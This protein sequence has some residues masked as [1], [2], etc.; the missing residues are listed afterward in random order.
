MDNYNV[1]MI[2]PSGAGKTVFLASMYKLLSIQRGYTSF[3]LE[4]D[5]EQRKLLNDKYTQIAGPGEWPAPTQFREISEWYFRVCI[6]N[7]SFQKFPA[8]QFTYLDY[9]GERIVDTRSNEESVS[10]FEIKLKNAD[11]IL[12]ILDGRKILSLMGDED[13]GQVFVLRELANI[14]QIIQQTQSP[15]HF[16]LSKWDLLNGKYTLKEIRDRLMD[17]DD[18]RELVKK[19]GQKVP[20]RLIPVSSVGMGFAELQPDGEMRKI[21]GAQAKPFQVE[22]PIACVLPD[23]LTSQLQKIKEKELKIQSK[24]IESE[25]DLTIWDILGE[26]VGSGLRKLRDYLRNEYQFSDILLKMLIDYAEMGASEKRKDAAQ[27]AEKLRQEKENSL[28]LVQNEKT[29]IEHALRSFLYLISTLERDFP[30]S[31]LI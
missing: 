5:P 24:S 6:E 16:V 26:W 22:I 31:T 10:D 28:K 7:D 3:F 23:Q 19:R 1:I 25:P 21:R 18:F 9:A 14:L 29:A 20:I 11:A 30:D 12:G 4:V 27:R 2:G 13:D 17:N 8:F 15:I